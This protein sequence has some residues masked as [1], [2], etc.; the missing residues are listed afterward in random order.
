MSAARSVFRSAASRASSTAFR[1]SAGPKPMPSSAR[2][3][4]RMPKQSPLTNRIFRSPVELSCCVETMLPYHT[5]TASALLNSMLSVSRR[6]W[7]VD[8]LD[9]TR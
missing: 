8:G 4:F 3:A 1:F 5:A 7:I 2:T 6:G 9:E